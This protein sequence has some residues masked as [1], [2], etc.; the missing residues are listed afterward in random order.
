MTASEVTLLPQP[1]SPTMPS[2]R[3]RA[4]E[5]L[6][7]STA[8]VRRPSV[9]GKTTRRSSTSSSGAPLMAIG[10]ARRRALS[11]SA[12]DDVAVGG[13]DRVAASRHELAEVHAALAADLL[14][15]RQFGERI[16]VVVD[17]QV[18]V[19][20]FLGRVDESAA[21]C[22]P[23]LSPPASSPGPQ[24]AMSRRAKGSAAAPR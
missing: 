6:T 2:V 9:P 8:S 16:G 12:F 20:V 18:E 5:K 14:Q 21:D 17:P 7:P 4:T 22:L 24:A 11:I 13:A 1:D 23:R 10:F 19:G 15:P 3:P